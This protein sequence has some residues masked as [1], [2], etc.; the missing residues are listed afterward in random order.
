[1]LSTG[2]H[3]VWL[4]L[5]SYARTLPSKI[6]PHV[7][8]I[9]SLLELLMGTGREA[10]PVPTPQCTPVCSQHVHSGV[11]CLEQKMLGARPVCPRLSLRAGSWPCHQGKRLHLH[12]CLH[13]CDVGCPLGVIPTAHSSLQPP[14]HLSC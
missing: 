12:G 6:S 9:N 4:V 2:I 10:W 7:K 1:M 11:A 5:G 13:P 8:Q 14:T 3:S